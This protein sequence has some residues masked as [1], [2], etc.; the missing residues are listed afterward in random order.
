M[1]SSEGVKSPQPVSKIVVVE[2]SSARRKAAPAHGS[3]TR[4]NKP[5]RRDYD[6]DACDLIDED[7]EALEWVGWHRR[8]SQGD[9]PR[10]MLA[11]R[12][13]LERRLAPRQHEL[14]PAEHHE[15]VPARGVGVRKATKLTESEPVAVADAGLP[16]RRVGLRVK[17]AGDV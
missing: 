2:A 16:G 11:G 13:E 5:S 6:Q 15:C 4:P 14:K 8:C 7:D 12:L 9:L 1:T 17:R 10:W 3:W